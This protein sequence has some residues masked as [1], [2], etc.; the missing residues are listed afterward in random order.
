VFNASIT[1]TDAYGIVQAID[2]ARA[3]RQKLVLAMTG[4]KHSSYME[5]GKFD[6]WKWKAR[7]NTYKTPAIKAAVAAAVADGTVLGNTV[8]DE[9]E[10]WGSVT[11]A[12]IN[13]MGAYV[14]SIF[15]TLPVGVDHGPNG[16]YQ[17]QPWER[18]TALDYVMNQYNWWVTTGDVVTWREKVL[19]QARRDGVQVA[20]GLNVLGGGIHSWVTQACPIP[21]TGGKGPFVPTCRMTPNQVRVGGLAVGTYGC[22]LFLWEYDAT[23]MSNA[24]NQ[25]A[26]KDLG[27]KLAATPALSCRRP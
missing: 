25:Q 11:K 18:Y 13:Q 10:V 19:A 14:K 1:Y 20:F 27:A 7:M 3:M 23:F 26:F 22:G 4:G 15:P 6:L 24:A 21:L 12:L 2:A 8:M 16:Y 9:P 17:W 5:K